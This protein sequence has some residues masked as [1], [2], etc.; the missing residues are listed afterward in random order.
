M[1]T[2]SHLVPW[3]ALLASVGAV[4]AWLTGRLTRPGSWWHVLDHP[5]ERSLHTRPVPRGGGVAIL[6]SL[7]AGAALA[8]PWLE[9]PGPLPWI[10]A[11]LLGLGLIS[12]VEDRRE[13]PRRYRLLAQLGAAGMLLAGGLEIQH[14]EFAGAGLALAPW[15]A[16]SLTLLYCVWMTN[17][18][19][20]MDGMDGLAAGMALF[21]FATLAW[22]GGRAGD[23]DFALICALVATASGGFLIWNFPPARIFMGDTGSTGLGFLAAALSLWGNQAGLFPLWVALLV[24][25]PFI[26]DA[27]LTLLLRLLRGERIWSAHRDHCYQRLV[28]AGWSHRRTLTRAYPLMA[29]CALSATQAVTM[30]PHE[31]VGLVVLWAVLYGLILLKVRWLERSG[32]APAP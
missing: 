8:Y 32:R 22:L 9:R 17:L 19:N 14:L 31:Q 6:A 15:L 5:N 7:L 23:L 30:A 4:S 24:F 28:A 20:F 21:G 16:A 29:A 1:T 18:Y 2:G 3:V 27:T 25:S 12:Y 13:I 11:G 26:L 10:G